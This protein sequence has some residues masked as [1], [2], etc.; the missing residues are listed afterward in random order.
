MKR[1]CE[2]CGKEMP[3]QYVLKTT[4]KITIDYIS[5]KELMGNDCLPCYVKKSKLPKKGGRKNESR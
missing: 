2:T 5:W 3:E 4:P 1:I